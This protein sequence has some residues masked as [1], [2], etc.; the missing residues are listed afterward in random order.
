MNIYFNQ[1]QFDLS[2]GKPVSNWVPFLNLR[3]DFKYTCC[4]KNRPEIVVEYV[5]KQPFF[6]LGC[7][8]NPC[9]CCEYNF[10]IFHRSSIAPLYQ[11]NADC[12]QCGFGC[13]CPCEPCKEVVFNILDHRKGASKV[14]EIRKVNSAL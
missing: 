2:T 11:V 7:V 9:V 4:N 13:R 14:G 8:R 1:L 6:K 12:C 3:R 5:Y 10:E